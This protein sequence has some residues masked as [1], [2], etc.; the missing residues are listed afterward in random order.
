[1]HCPPRTDGVERSVLVA[2][3]RRKLT[4]DEARG[5]AISAVEA[6]VAA[7]CNWGVLGEDWNV[8]DYRFLVLEF[9]PAEGECLYIQ[10]WTEPGESVVVEACS[11]AWTPSARKY[12]RTPQRAA[13]R[14]LGYEI[15]GRAR[16]FEKRWRVTN[17]GGARALASELVNI[18]VNIFGYRGRQPLLMQYCAE[19]RAHH[20]PV[21]NG[22]VI[23]DVRRMLAIAGMTAIPYEP[24]RQPTPGS[25]SNWPPASNQLGPTNQPAI[26]RELQRSVLMVEKPFTFAIVM[27]LKSKPVPPTYNGLS[28]L[29]VLDD[30]VGLSDADLIAINDLIPCGRFAQDPLGRIEFVLE[31]WLNGITVGWFVSMMEAWARFRNQAAEL[32]RRT[33]RAN[34]PTAAESDDPDLDVGDRPAHRVRTVA[35]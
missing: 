23:D 34:C 8:G 14:A 16:N 29:S 13:L 26:L 3:T 7:T 19:G 31:L 18:L 24:R 4:R 21:F 12:I 33:R 1:V 6:V 15:G 11:G 22:L 10:L 32:I 35:H 20:E 28:L 5:R 27:A 25:E 17:S 9:W 2:S 30:G